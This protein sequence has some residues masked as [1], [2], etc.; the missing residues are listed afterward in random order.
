MFLIKTITFFI[1]KNTLTNIKKNCINYLVK[2]L[3]T[4]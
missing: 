3:K 2:K 1:E 4:Y